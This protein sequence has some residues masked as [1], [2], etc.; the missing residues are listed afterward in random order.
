MKKFVLV[1]L[2]ALLITGILAGCSSVGFSYI[3]KKPSNVTTD[4]TAISITDID[5]KSAETETVLAESDVSNTVQDETY[6]EI[7]DDSKVLYDVRQYEV[8]SQG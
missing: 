8:T 5:M 7:Y 6:P 1:G 3:N 4:G 2:S